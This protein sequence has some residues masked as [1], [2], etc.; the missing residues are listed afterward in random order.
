MSMLTKGAALSRAALIALY[1][2]SPMNTVA[3][4]ETILPPWHKVSPRRAAFWLPMITVEA[5]E[6]VLASAP[7]PVHNAGSPTRAAGRLSMS[8]V[9][10]PEVM[11]PP[12]CG[13]GPGFTK[14]QDW[15]S[16]TR[17]A[18]GTSLF[19]PYSARKYLV[20]PASCGKSNPSLSLSHCLCRPCRRACAS[21]QRRIERTG[22]LLRARVGAEGPRRIASWCR[23]G[24][25][26]GRRRDRAAPWGTRPPRRPTQAGGSRGV[27]VYCLP[28]SSYLAKSRSTYRGR[29]RPN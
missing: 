21:R 16:P 11:G 2:S 28:H 6:P 3:A 4:P 26:P 9:F 27:G 22:G 23:P 12:T 25:T 18:G 10:S 29:Q 24:C 5:P 17:A 14:G 13:V 7:T 1:D 15:M 19:L 20:S 8:T